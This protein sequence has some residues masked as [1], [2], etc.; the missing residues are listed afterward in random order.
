MH[1][2]HAVPNVVDQEHKKP[3]PGVGITVTA[4]LQCIVP[5]LA[6]TG[7]MVHPIG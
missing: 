6:G 7:P 5:W 1:L 4:R 3:S 2:I